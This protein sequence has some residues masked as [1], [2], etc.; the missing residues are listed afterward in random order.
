MQRSQPDT[1]R[2]SGLTIDDDDVAPTVD[3][4]DLMLALLDGTS[5]IGAPIVL[6]DLPEW[7]PAGATVGVYL[8]GGT[9]RYVGGRWVLE[10]G[11]SASTGLG[12]SAAWDELDPSWQWDQWSPEITW[13]DLRGVAAPTGG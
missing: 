5:R 10:L 2:A 6:G 9:Y 7:T 13:D 4:V 3:G 1:W 12:E 11:V 8:E